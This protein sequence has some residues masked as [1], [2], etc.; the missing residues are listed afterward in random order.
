MAALDKIEKNIPNA[1]NR[2]KAKQL[3]SKPLQN[4]FHARVNYLSLYYGENFRGDMMMPS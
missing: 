2:R 1:E 4:N 3:R